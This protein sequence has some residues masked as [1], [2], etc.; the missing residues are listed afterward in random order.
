MSGSAYDG[1]IAV[2]D[3]SL[4]LALL[5]AP[6]SVESLRRLP[7][8]PDGPGLI[9]YRPLLQLLLSPSNIVAM[10][11]DKGSDRDHKKGNGGAKGMQAPSPLRLRLNAP[12]QRLLHAI[13]KSMSTFLT[14]NSQ[15]SDT[16]GDEVG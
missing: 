12:L 7:G 3:M 9:S 5:N 6:V 14:N 8:V 1:L 11:A 16:I 4:C 2:D 10:T 15:V 13:R